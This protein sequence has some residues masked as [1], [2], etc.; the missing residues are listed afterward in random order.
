MLKNYLEFRYIG[1][2]DYEEK[3]KEILEILEYIAINIFETLHNPTINS[4]D[5]DKFISI[6]NVELP[7]IDETLNLS[8]YMEWDIELYYNSNNFKSTKF[9]SV[10][11]YG[12][13]RN[14][15]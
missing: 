1:G 11:I 7:Q 10:F 12:F 14:L 9:P 5:F 6:V 8:K 2:E 4:Q 3:E 15:Q 13:L